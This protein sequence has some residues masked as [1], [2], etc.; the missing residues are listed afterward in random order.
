MPAY[1]LHESLFTTTDCVAAIHDGKK[2]F[3]HVFDMVCGKYAGNICESY[4]RHAVPNVRPACIFRILPAWRC[5]NMMEIHAGHIF[6]TI[7]QS[8][9]GA[10]ART[11]SGV[12][13]LCWFVLLV[14]AQAPEHEIWM[15]NP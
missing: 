9:G 13:C 15:T 5:K 6:H 4:S 11:A 8:G 3:H 7:W 10:R 14:C 12:C 2:G 1:F